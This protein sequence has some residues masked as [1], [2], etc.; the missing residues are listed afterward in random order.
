L[1]KDGSVEAVQSLQFGIDTRKPKATAPSIVPTCT[2][3][4]RIVVGNMAVLPYSVVDQ[5]PRGGTADVTIKIT[6]SAGTLVKTLTDDTVP[7]NVGQ[8]AVFTWNLPAGNYRYSVYAVD[9]AGNAQS[10]VGSRS[11]IAYAN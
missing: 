4:Y 8:A 10:K 9:A 5:A 1:A 7:V 11:I 3:D 2:Y 6:N